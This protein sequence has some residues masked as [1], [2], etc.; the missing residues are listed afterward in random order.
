MKSILIIACCAIATCFISCKKKTDHGIPTILKG[1]VMDSIRGTSISG[2]KITLIKKVGQDCAN[3]QCGTI[4]E[5]VATVYTDNN[6]DYLINFDHHVLPGQE[7]Y[8]KEEYYG[9]PYFH[10]SSS[11]T[12]A[13][14]GCGTNIINVNA[15]KPVELKLNVQVLNNHTPPLNM[16]NVLASTN[17]TL[18]NVESVYQQN[19][20]S[21]YTLR[22]RPNSDINII[23]YY[24]VNYASPTPTTHQM[25]I[26]Y[27]STLD[28]VTTLNFTIDCSTF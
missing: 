27:H 24:T 2:Y 3:W 6:G 1:H 15:W 26:P 9:I 25:I 22:T 11:G 16:R 13:I 7:Y 21:T 23:F 8:Y 20:N 14:V 17:Q 28:S 19:M 10:E 4:F 12:G 18:L 5:N